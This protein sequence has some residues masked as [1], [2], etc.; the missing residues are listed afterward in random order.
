MKKHVCSGSASAHPI[1]KD[2]LQRNIVMLFLP[3][4]GVVVGKE[5]WRI[6]AQI[7]FKRIYSNSR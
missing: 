7:E 5:N 3:L 1:I 4:P 2:L 6:P